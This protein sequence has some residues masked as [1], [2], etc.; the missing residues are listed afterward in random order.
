[1]E[2]QTS[3]PQNRKHPRYIAW[4]RAMVFI[5][6][7][8]EPLP[9]HIIDISEGGVSFHYLGKKIKFEERCTINLYH[10]NELI[11]DDLPTNLISDNLMR[12]GLVPK[13]R[14]SLCFDSLSI[15]QK[16]KLLA[17]INSFTYPLH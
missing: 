14:R 6:K 3:Y 2:N 9:Y 13:R 11:I 4:P 10:E 5:E 8:P 17:Y 12:N 1:M 7:S 15:N 16:T